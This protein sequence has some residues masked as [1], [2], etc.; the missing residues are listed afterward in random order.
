MQTRIAKRVA[1]LVSFSAAL[2]GCAPQETRTHYTSYDHSYRPSA[3][4]GNCGVVDRIEQVS[5]RGGNS[6][7]GTVVG[8][9]A[10]G[11]LGSTIGKGDGNTA[12]TVVGAV[13]GG[14]VGNRVGG[15]ETMNYRIDV[16]MDD[17][18]RATVTQRQDPQIRPGDY[19]EI[20]GDRI[21]RK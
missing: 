17:G 8:A 21:Y 4:C 13:A 2:I 7:L 16:R 12:A 14:V 5:T 19:V 20:R 11:V 15:R 9:V 10:G 6:T 3:R 18:R 1:L